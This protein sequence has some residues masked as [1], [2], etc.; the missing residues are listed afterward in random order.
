MFF[1]TST[2]PPTFALHGPRPPV[3]TKI[4]RHNNADDLAHWQTIVPH[5]S[6]DY[7]MMDSIASLAAISRHPTGMVASGG[8][9]G[10]VRVQSTGGI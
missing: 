3:M 1:L 8:L 2:L 9:T 4:R 6:A 5:M 7:V 10:V